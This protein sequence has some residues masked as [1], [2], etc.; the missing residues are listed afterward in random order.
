M[1]ANF[2]KNRVLALMEVES[3]L[4]KIAIFFLNK[5]ERP[6]EAPFLFLEKK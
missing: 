5:K 4:Q 3:F 1:I 6:T 2:D